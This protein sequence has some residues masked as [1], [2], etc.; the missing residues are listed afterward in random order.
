MAYILVRVVEYTCYAV[1]FGAIGFM[2]IG[3]P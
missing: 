1:I 2:W 3:T